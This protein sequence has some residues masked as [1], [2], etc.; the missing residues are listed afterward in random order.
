MHDSS[1]PWFGIGGVLVAAGGL[2]VLL[3]APT[4]VSRY[5]VISLNSILMYLVLTVSWAAFCGPT[6]YISLASA[7]FFGVGIYTSA[8]LG[9]AVPL[10]VLTLVGGLLS[11]GLAFLV[12]LSSLRLRGMYFTIF[13]FGLSELIRH[14]VLWWEVNIT[15]TVG[16]VVFSVG[17]VTVYYSMIAIA[18]A[19]VIGAYCLQVSRFGLALRGIGESEEAADHIGINV[20]LIKIVTFA[21]TSFFMG[22][23]GVV[24]ATRWTYIDPS[25]AFN[26]LFSFMPVLM[27]IF[28]GIR[29]IRGQ[30]VGAVALTLLA[31]LLLTTFPYYY[32]LLYGIILVAVILFM[33]QG[34]TGFLERA[35]NWARAAQA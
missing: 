25:I 27:A 6:N 9:T 2:V 3:A 11:F 20:D 8:T 5:T 19:T 24:M 31:D 15:G 32:N 1:Q 17:D 29:N 23:A 12:G 34:L 7:A 22:C 28:G 33:P 18:L 21:G 26:P 14:A 16:R 30:V 13:T 10:P 4:F 35:R